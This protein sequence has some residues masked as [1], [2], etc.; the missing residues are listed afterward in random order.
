MAKVVN[1]QRRTPRT[2]LVELTEGEADFILGVT[3]RVAGHETRSMAKYS[4][5]LR[6]VLSKTLGYDCDETD[7]DKYA[8]GFL[9]LNTYEP[10][11]SYDKMSDRI[12]FEL[13]HK[14]VAELDDPDN[15]PQQRPLPRLRDVAAP[16]ELDW[17]AR[18]AEWERGVM[19]QHDAR[20][21]MA[22]EMDPADVFDPQDIER[23]TPE[24]MENW[25]SRVSRYL[26]R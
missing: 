19:T 15:A 9:Y 1:S 4:T 8:R 3:S 6:K 17:Q 11:S 10:A 22:G 26:S 2:I 18:A 7:F 13:N 25:W 21:I 16:V 14:L 20:A 23:D 5:R 12:S 24:E